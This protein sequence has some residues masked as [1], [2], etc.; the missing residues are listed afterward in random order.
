MC[1]CVC[2]C[3]KEKSQDIN[4]KQRRQNLPELRTH[5]L[6]V[7]VVSMQSA[8]DLT[9]YHHHTYVCFLLTFSAT[10][11]IQYEKTFSYF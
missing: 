11:S 9:K 2:V 3:V 6:A 10:L 5:L 8:S 1:V 7:A 4:T